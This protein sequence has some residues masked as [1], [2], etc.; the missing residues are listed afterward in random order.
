MAYQFGT[1]LDIGSGTITGSY[2][3][4]SREEGDADLDQ[5]DIF[6]E[7]GDRET[8]IQ[9]NRDP[10]I[11]LNLICLSGAAPETDFIKG[12]IASHTDFTT[13]FVDDARYSKSKSAR[14]VSV[15]LTNIGIT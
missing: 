1:T 9:L 15:T 4:E 12:T 8:R 13:Y 3:V 10:K 5:E 7:D 11:V 2:I 6:D 14:R